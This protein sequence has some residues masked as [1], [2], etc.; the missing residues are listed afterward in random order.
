MLEPTTGRFVS[1][2]S[3]GRIVHY[4]VSTDGPCLAA[5][6]VAV[7]PTGNVNLAVFDEAADLVDRHGIEKAA[8]TAS[9]APETIGGVWHW[10]ERV[11][12]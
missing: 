5:I 3:V 11:D 4:R 6:V 1:R 2:P 8:D 9:G 12:G 10:P 7:H